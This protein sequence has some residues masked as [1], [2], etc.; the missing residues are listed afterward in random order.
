MQE[1]TKTR[2]TKTAASV[3][4]QAPTQGRLPRC[5]PS[6]Q[7]GSTRIF[8]VKEVAN[9]AWW[10]TTPA[11]RGLMCAHNAPQEGTSRRLEPAPASS[12]LRVS[13]RI[14]VKLSV[15]S[16]RQGVTHRQA[17]VHADHA[18]QGLINPHRHRASVSRALLVRWQPRGKLLAPNAKL[19][20][21]PMAAHAVPASQGHTQI[22]KQRPCAPSARQARR[23][24][25]MLTTAD[26]V[27]SASSPHQAL[28]LVER[29]QLATTQA[30]GPRDALHVPQGNSVVP[31]VLKPVPFAPRVG[32]PRANQ[33]PVRLVLQAST[34]PILV[35]PPATPP[36]QALPVLQAALLL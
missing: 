25:P 28:P 3:V 19:E 31:L 15:I 26:P 30:Q 24:S 6:A 32:S 5:A 34:W 18:A 12:V 1:R 35:P 27:L 2:N 20:S 10:A 23:P 14:P 7:W 33:R 16:A 4:S 9:H 13:I 11:I 8:C 17:G 21:T 29:A 36:L 22:R